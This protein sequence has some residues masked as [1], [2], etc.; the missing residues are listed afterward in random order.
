[1]KEV[2]VLYKR[3][4]EKVYDEGILESIE[5]MFVSKEKALERIVEMTGKPPKNDWSS[6]SYYDDVEFHTFVSLCVYGPY[7]VEED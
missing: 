5:G 4:D 1:M 7:E 3:T 6:E 2:W